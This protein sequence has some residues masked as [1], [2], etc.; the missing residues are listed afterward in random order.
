MCF[1]MKRTFCCLLLKKSRSLCLLTNLRQLLHLVN[2]CNLLHRRRLV[3]PAT[4]VQLLCQVQPSHLCL[5]LRRCWLST[6][7]LSTRIRLTLMRIRML[8]QACG[9]TV[10]RPLF[11]R[12]S[13]IPATSV[14]VE[15][16]FLQG[17]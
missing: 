3:C 13:C 11:K 1:I 7:S 8:T 14:P 9:C 10:I 16:V 4:N 6:S 15:C 5:H 17:A 2:L 12:Q